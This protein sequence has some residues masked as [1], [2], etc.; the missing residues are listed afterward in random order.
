[1]REIPLDT[2]GEGAFSRKSAAGPRF[3]KELNMVDIARRRSETSNKMASIM[4]RSRKNG[5]AGLFESKYARRLAAQGAL[6]FLALLYWQAAVSWSLVSNSQ[7]AS[8]LE[9]GASLAT[10]VDDD[11]Y[12]N[13]VLAT[14][15]SW[16]IGVLIS[17]CAGIGLG[18]PIGASQFWTV[19]TRL[20]IDFLRTIPPVALV[21]L[22]LLLFGPTSLMKVVLIVAGAIWAVLVQA[23]YAAQQLDP[24]ISDVL[25][26]FRMPSAYRVAYARVPAALPFLM[27][28]VRVASNISLLLGITVELVAGAPGIGNAIAQAQ[29]GNNVPDM[30]AYVATATILGVAI[31]IAL[32]ALQRRLL[33]WHPS[34]RGENQ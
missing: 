26:S 25:R 5:D 2:E 15:Q 8:P 30:Y 4:G 12:W 28:G 19:S 14:L 3:M 16:G 24:A 23:I 32:S 27:T 34:V 10:L 22:V 9:I 18:L 17:L 7:I 1:V 21:P 11:Q 33:W 20:P 6:I 29:I 31:N 13:A